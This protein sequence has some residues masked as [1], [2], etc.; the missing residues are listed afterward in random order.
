MEINQQ[1]LILKVNQHYDKSKLNLDKWERFLDVLCGNRE[2]QKQAI[3]CAI[4]FFASGLYTSINDLV[5]ENYKS[6]NELKK[7]MQHMMITKINCK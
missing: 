2:Y 3:R 6:N 5:K 7:N 4:I 1:N